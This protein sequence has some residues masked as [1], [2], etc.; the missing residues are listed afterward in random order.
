ME[1]LSEIADQLLHAAWGFGVIAVFW[2]VS[3]RPRMGPMALLGG[4]VAAI[5]MALPREL[6]DQWP[7]N[8][9]W[10]TVLDLCLFGIGG[11]LG[12]L[13]AWRVRK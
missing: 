9:W 2:A 1:I 13:L 3:G 7:I 6:V 12:G 4:A 8:R 10:D 11:M 5:G